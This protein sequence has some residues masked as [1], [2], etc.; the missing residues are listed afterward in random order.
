MLCAWVAA[1]LLAT[2]CGATDTGQAVPSSGDGSSSDSS[3]VAVP[4]TAVSSESSAAP[5]L[6][7]PC[8]LLTEQQA[9]VLHVEM[10]GERDDVGTSI[11]CSWN[12]SDATYSVG[13]RTNAGLAQVRANGG[14]VTDV[15]VGSHNGKIVRNA[16]TGCIEAIGIT[17][18][19]RVEIVAVTNDGETSSA[20]AATKR[21]AKL[22]ETNL[23]ST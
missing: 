3:T 19:S 8:S 13:I 23:P 6:S 10:P 21:F 12:S 16:A 22:V 11:G 15:S 5:D 17:K 18:H 4:T 9:K 2:A 7:A 20:C 1:S 14:V